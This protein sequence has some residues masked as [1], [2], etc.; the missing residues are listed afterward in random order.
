MWKYLIAGKEM[1]GLPTVSLRMAPPSPLRFPMWFGVCQKNDDREQGPPR[2]YR[3]SKDESCG[4]WLAKVAIK[5]C[6]KKVASSL[7]L[8]VINK[9][10]YMLHQMTNVWGWMG[11]PHCSEVFLFWVLNKVV[12]K[13]PCLSRRCS[14]NIREASLFLPRSTSPQGCPCWQRVPCHSSRPSKSPMGYTPC[15]TQR[16]CQPH[17]PRPEGGTKEF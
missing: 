3:T 8:S 11:L 7:A 2:E 13:Q 10:R 5:R 4:A 16:F 14:G 6:C 9:F 12:C 15:A 1:M 17:L